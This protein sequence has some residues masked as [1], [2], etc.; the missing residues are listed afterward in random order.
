MTTRI[1]LVSLQVNAAAGD[2][3]IFVLLASLAD[4]STANL[5]IRVGPVNPV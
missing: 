4:E 1:P 2:H 3:D 5:D